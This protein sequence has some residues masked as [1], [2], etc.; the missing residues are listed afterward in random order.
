MCGKSVCEENL[1]AENLL[2]RSLYKKTFRFVCQEKV[3]GLLR[4]FRKK[5]EQ[6]LIVRKTH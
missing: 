4:L 3:I 1:C 5:C 2:L 6:E